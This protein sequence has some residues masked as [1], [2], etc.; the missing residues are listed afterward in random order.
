M[1]VQADEH[2]RMAQVLGKAA[3]D[4]WGELPRNVQESLFELAVRIGHVGERDESL[5]EQ[6]AQ[7]LHDHNKWTA[8][9]R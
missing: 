1:V 6:L 5:R 3:I 7:Y 2:A 9:R 4:L 8:H